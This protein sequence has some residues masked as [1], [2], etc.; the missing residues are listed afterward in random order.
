M[1][2]QDVLEA[3]IEEWHASVNSGHPDRAAASVGNP[4]VV[5]GPKGAGAITP[6]Q[7]AE[8]VVRSGI[9]L[10]PLVWHPVSKRLIVVTQAATWPE[11]PE[12][13]KVATVFRVV[14][15]KVTAALRMP[16]QASALE[17]AGVYRAL[18]ATE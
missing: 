12:P 11:S 14:N 7:F 9:R 3:T 8:W 1:T 2:E 16:D 17:L 15:G 5:L 6:A 18:A 13:V 10:E 4:V